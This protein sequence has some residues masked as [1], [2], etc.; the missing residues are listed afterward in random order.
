MILMGEKALQIVWKSDDE[1]SPDEKKQLDLIY[2]LAFH[3]EEPDK[4][5]IEW[6]W[7]FYH[8]LG[9]IDGVIVSNVGIVRKEITVKGRTIVVGGVGGVVTHPDWRRMGFARLLMDKAEEYLRR[10]SSEYEY[11]MLFCDKKMVPYYG[12]GGW[13][14]IENLVYITWK[15]ERKISDEICMVLQLSEKEWPPGE[16]DTQG[17]PW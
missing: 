15:K 9:K 11:G 5:N 17:P 6:E 12:K 4:E 7:P 10:N 1:F 14:Q 2:T 3:D 16:V 13:V 8:Y